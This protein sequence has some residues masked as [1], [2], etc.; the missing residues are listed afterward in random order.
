MYSSIFFERFQTY[1]R[2]KTQYVTKNEEID[3]QN[4]IIKILLTLAFNLIK[5]KN[6]REILEN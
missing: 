6:N 2:S 4:N 3:S 1:E 5:S